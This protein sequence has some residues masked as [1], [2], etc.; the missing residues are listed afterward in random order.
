MNR[1]PAFDTLEPRQ[2]PFVLILLRL[3]VAAVAAA[4]LGACAVQLAPDYDA[5]LLDGLMEANE[6]ALV[7]F[8][9]VETGSPQNQFAGL[10]DEY[11]LVIA[12]FD[13]LK[14]RAAARQNPPLTQRLAKMKFFATFCDSASDPGGCL[15]ATESS[16]TE[17]LDTFR[18]MRNRHRDQSTGLGE[19]DV[20]LFRGRYD[21][22]MH[23]ALTVETALKR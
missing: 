3:F 13:A 2:N 17:V 18:T 4:S 8:A 21:I 6:E 23:Q 11:A 12:K 19:V 9:K 5:Q 1:Q 14:Q 10:A 16:L 22:Q 15:N 20:Q 7:L